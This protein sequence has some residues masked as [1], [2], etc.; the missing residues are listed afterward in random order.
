MDAKKL[1]STPP[2]RLD[3]FRDYDEFVD[4][5]GS[6]FDLT[7]EEFEGLYQVLQ[8]LQLQK[9]LLSLPVVMKL[10][11]GQGLVRFTRYATQLLKI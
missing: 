4:Y 6:L 3:G 1:T 8:K 2:S 10:H 7:E 11:Q 5:A 9:L